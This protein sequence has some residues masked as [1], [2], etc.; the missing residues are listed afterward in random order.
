MMSV[1]ISSITRAKG[2]W[3]AYRID[4]GPSLASVSSTFSIVTSSETPGQIER[5]EQKFV[6]KV[7]VT[8]PEMAT[9]IIYGKN[10]LISSSPELN[11]LET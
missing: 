6:H 11:D 2:S 5:I 10:L 1:F 4:S 8:F 3:E 9:T 7:W